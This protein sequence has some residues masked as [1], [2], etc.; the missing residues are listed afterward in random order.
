MYT[1]H[2]NNTYKISYC[3]YYDPNCNKNKRMIIL[4]SKTHSFPLIMDDPEDINTKTI[5]NKD[6]FLKMLKI[7]LENKLNYKNI[8]LK[9]HNIIKFRI[10]TI[11]AII[12]NIS[13]DTTI[14]TLINKKFDLNWNMKPELLWREN[15]YNNY[16]KVELNTE[17]TQKNSDFLKDNYGRNVFCI[18]LFTSLINTMV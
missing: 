11:L 15:N 10:L 2:V 1:F 16:F 7:C 8:Q 12:T 6:K 17:D 13:L 5:F 3:L 9:H 4:K 18:S 14:L